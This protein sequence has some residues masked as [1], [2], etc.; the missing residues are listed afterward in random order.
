MIV[1]IAR[2]IQWLINTDLMA[3]S[4]DNFQN[5]LQQ[6]QRL[7][8]GHSNFTFKYNESRTTVKIDY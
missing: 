5:E 4:R 8:K 3:K 2:Q 7:S 1:T 6:F